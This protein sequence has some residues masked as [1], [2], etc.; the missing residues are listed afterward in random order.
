MDGCTQSRIRS[1]LVSP[2]LRAT[3]LCFEEDTSFQ[4]RKIKTNI[5]EITSDI[6]ITKLAFRPS[7]CGSPKTP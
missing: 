7:R 1:T 6:E 3:R 4:L 2:A 5:A